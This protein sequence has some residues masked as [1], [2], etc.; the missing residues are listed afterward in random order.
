M[1]L[2]Q[3]QWGR[4]INADGSLER[5]GCPGLLLFSVVA[6]K[7]VDQVTFSM[8]RHCDKGPWSPCEKSGI[9]QVSWQIGLPLGQALAGCNGS[10]W[11]MNLPASFCLYSAA[12]KIISWRITDWYGA[13]IS[14]LGYSLRNNSALSLHSASVNNSPTSIACSLAVWDLCI[15]SP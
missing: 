10:F 15:Q 2:L 12:C 8:D 1:C 7:V 3:L 6:H 13:F 5:T 11:Q 4:P 9:P 14:Y